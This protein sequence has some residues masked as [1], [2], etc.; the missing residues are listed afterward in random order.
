M[1]GDHTL[2]FTPPPSE[3]ILEVC[4]NNRSDTP[5]SLDHGMTDSAEMSPSRSPMLTDSESAHD[6]LPLLGLEMEV[7]DYLGSY[8]SKLANSNQN[9]NEKIF[10]CG[11]CGYTVPGER[12]LSS[13]NEIFHSSP[14]CGT[15]APLCWG[16]CGREVNR[17]QT[18]VSQSTNNGRGATKNSGF[19]GLQTNRK[20]PAIDCKLIKYRGVLQEFWTCTVCGLANRNIGSVADHVMKFHG[21]PGTHQCN[22][23]NNSFSDEQ[24]LRRHT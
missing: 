14:S 1:D 18:T 2:P 15:C 24:A 7:D 20:P 5:S 4:D 22:K 19:R 9:T 3:I 13:H 21:L 17:T 10:S 6:P 12:D 11:K 8:N 16:S 23:C